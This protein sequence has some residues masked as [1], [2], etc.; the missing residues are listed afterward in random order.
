ML[1]HI[2]TCIL[3]TFKITHSQGAGYFQLLQWVS[4]I[5]EPIIYLTLIASFASK[6]FPTSDAI[7]YFAANPLSFLAS[8]LSWLFDSWQGGLGLALATIEPQSFS[9]EI[10]ALACSGVARAFPGGRVA[11]PEGQNE[12]EN[13][14]SLRKR[15]KNWSKFEE[16][17]RKVELLPT[18]DCEAG[19]SPASM[20]LVSI[21]HELRH[22]I[23]LDHE[24][25]STA[26]G[27]SKA[28]AMR[29]NTA[30]SLANLSSK[31]PS[32]LY[33]T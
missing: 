6:G 33:W 26:T 8:V 31:L 12:E 21:H 4:S 22:E 19:Y 2:G 3:G 1:S 28:S 24:W 11:H 14:R 15:K 9:L 29:K 25:T 10:S 27:C 32:P 18:R 30:S 23:E 5:F 17:V 16:T 20:Y 7:T 13:E